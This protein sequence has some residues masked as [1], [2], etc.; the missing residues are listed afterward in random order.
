MGYYVTIIDSDAVIPADNLAEAY[1]RL[2]ELN[3]R[4]DLKT[5]GRWNAEGKVESWFAW[6]PTDYPD[7]CANAQEIFEMLGFG[8]CSLDDGSLELNEYDSKTGSEDVFLAAVCDLFA[9]GSYIT[10]RG[11][12]DETWRD[13][14]G[15]AEVTHSRG[16]VV[17]D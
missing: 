10:W 5:G 15:D 4:D 1:R 11:E 16:R 14:Y 2:C 8:T 7:Q 6:M 3:K 9:P 12:D 13:Y 17:F